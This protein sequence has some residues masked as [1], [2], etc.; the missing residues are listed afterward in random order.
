MM[1]VVAF[2]AREIAARE[3]WME[4]FVAGMSP[5]V[6]TLMVIVAWE[7][8]RSDTYEEHQKTSLLLIG[9]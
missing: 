4:G 3:T 7:I 8:F 6:A 1:L 9:C 5:A 2:V